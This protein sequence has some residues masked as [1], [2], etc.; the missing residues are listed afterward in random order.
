MQN[1][2]EVLQTERGLTAGFLGGDVGFQK[3]LVASRGAVDR[4]RGALAS[5]LATA[6]GPAVRR[7]DRAGRAGQHHRHH[8]A[9]G[10]DAKKL[11]RTVAFDY[12]TSHIGALTAVNF[13]LDAS[14]NRALTP[15][16]RR[17]HRAEHRQGAVLPR[18]ARC[19]TAS[20]RPAATWPASTTGTP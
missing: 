7:P 4:E 11:D 19:S 3:E 8:P 16:C 9:T 5:L 18:S 6:T 15:R 2:V 13:G 17:V 14:S 12:F 10:I 1:L 20:S